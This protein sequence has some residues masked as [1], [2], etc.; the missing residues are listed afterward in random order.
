MIEAVFFDCGSTLI[1]PHPSV[2]EVFVEVARRR[3]HVLALDEVRPHMEA[4]WHFYDMEY[5]KDGDFWSS[6]EGS[7]EIWLDIY[8]FLC[9]LTGLV[10]DV[11]GMAKAM[12]AEYLD[13]D[14]WFV[15]DDVKPC[16]RELKRRRIRLGIVSNWDPS[17]R[18]LM[19]AL[20]L[21]PYFDEVLSSADVGYRKPDPVFFQIGLERLGV[22]PASCV[23]VGDKVEAD[24]DGATAAGIHAVILDRSGIE[25]DSPYRKIS[26]LDELCGVLDM[27]SEPA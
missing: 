6:A 14:R 9:H 13:A 16:L 18:N 10:D 15:Y 26:S 11:E 23:H 1:D 2:E 12:F 19:R 17:L 24:G 20:G 25:P 22:A 21:T 4:V 3:G 7:R 8:R 27:W 5:L